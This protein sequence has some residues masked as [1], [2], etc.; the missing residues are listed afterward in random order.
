MDFI[1]SKAGYHANGVVIIGV[2]DMRKVGLPV[3]LVFVANYG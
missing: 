3:V 2:F 1:G